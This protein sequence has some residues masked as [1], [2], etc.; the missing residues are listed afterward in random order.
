MFA[1]ASPSEAIQAHPLP[2]I[3]TACLLFNNDERPIPALP[4]S[5][6]YKDANPRTRDEAAMNLV[7][8]LQQQ[9]E[10]GL[11][12]IGFSNARNQPAAAEFGL[13]L[14]EELPDTR[15]EEHYNSYKLF[16]GDHHISLVQAVALAY[17]SMSIYFGVGQAANEIEPSERDITVYMDRFPAARPARSEPGE[18]SPVTPGM[19]FVH[20]LRNHSPTGRFISAEESKMGVKLNLTTLEWWKPHRDEG[21]RPGKT[22]PMFTLVD[23]YVVSSLAKEFPEEFMKNYSNKRKSRDIVAALSNLYDEF[24]KFEIWS[25]GDDQS[26]KLISGANK[27]MHIPKPAREFILALAEKTP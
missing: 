22:F 6:Q 26:L 20:F 7:D 3:A 13:S 10:L 24:K 14:L 9:R 11:R 25:I 5:K 16:F 12:I 8:W 19:Q 15:I 27:N 4:F 2:G 18:K 23:W 21:W 17:Y 1:D